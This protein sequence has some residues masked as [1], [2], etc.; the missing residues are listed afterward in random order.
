MTQ[1]W[2]TAYEG[3]VSRACAPTYR[4]HQRKPRVGHLPSPQMPKH[5]PRC[6]S[7]Q[8]HQRGSYRHTVALQRTG[9]TTRGSADPSAP[10]SR[11]SDGHRNQAHQTGC[12]DWRTRA[13]SVDIP[14]HLTAATAYWNSP[15][16][17]QRGQVTRFA[18]QFIRRTSLRGTC[19][20]CWRC[21]TSACASIDMV[22][23]CFLR[24]ENRKESKQRDSARNGDS[25]VDCPA[26]ADRPRTPRGVG[27][28]RKRKGQP[29]TVALE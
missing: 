29:R 6:Q 5:S 23:P 11:S 10:G 19:L 1:L 7:S 27:G 25:V 24:T 16:D 14:E 26:H 22:R 4:K 20:C 2:D 21:T 28:V 18:I 17:Y 15:K 13:P 9:R 3:K 12:S 8:R